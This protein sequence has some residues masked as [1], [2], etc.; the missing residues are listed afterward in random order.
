MSALHSFNFITPWA[1]VGSSELRAQCQTRRPNLLI[2]KFGG[3]GETSVFGS[4][5]RKTARRNRSCIASFP[6]R[7]SN[8]SRPWVLRG[9]TPGR[10]NALGFSAVPLKRPA[11]VQP[12]CLWHRHDFFLRY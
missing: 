9:T 3:I 8:C 12:S 5:S 11:S 1:E 7:Q 6:P 10:K 4:V 2:Y